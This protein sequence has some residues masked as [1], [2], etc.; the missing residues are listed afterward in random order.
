[1]ALFV[2]NHDH[3]QDCTATAGDSLACNCG[4]WQYIKRVSK[5][6]GLIIAAAIESG[7]YDSVMTYIE[8]PKAGEANV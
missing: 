5:D 3:L 1:M 4:R 7:D 2:Y 8:S 6:L